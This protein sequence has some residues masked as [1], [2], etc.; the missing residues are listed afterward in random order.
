M[1]WTLF[2]ESSES[3]TFTP[4]T[5]KVGEAMPC[6][7]L[8]LQRQHTQSHKSANII[9]G[10]V[11]CFTIR[12]VR[13]KDTSEHGTVTVTC[14]SRH[15]LKPTSS[16]LNKPALPSNDSLSQSQLCNHVDHKGPAAV[17]QSEVAYHSR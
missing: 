3:L 8:K 7:S 13:T 6:S 2:D 9:S 10:T 11:A 16:Q 4:N 17:A 1:L 14:M 15:D 12:D 5:S